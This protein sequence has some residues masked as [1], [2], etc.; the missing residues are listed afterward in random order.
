MMMMPPPVSLRAASRSPTQQAPDPYHKP[1][2][3]ALWDCQDVQIYRSKSISTSL[4]LKGQQ[5]RS[6]PC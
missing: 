2:E 5:Q 3:G 1:L 6:A 4:A